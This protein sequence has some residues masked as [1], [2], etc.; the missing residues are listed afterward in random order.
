MLLILSV[1]KIVVACIS[2]PSIT[3]APTRSLLIVGIVI[4][5]TISSSCLRF[6]PE[7]ICNLVRDVILSH[8]IASIFIKELRA[9]ISPP[10]IVIP[11]APFK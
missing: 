2:C 3:P 11:F 9:I 4:P 5:S 10:S 1:N 6:K 7:L 8:S